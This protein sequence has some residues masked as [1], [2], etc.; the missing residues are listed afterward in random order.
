MARECLRVA[1]KRNF[2]SEML[3]SKATPFGPLLA[4]LERYISHSLSALADAFT[5]QHPFS[6]DDTV[7]RDYD[8]YAILAQEIATAR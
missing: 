1:V 5:L 3:F 7:T 4:V 8:G 2:C 6:S